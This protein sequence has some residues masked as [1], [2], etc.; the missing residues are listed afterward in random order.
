[1]RIKL[2]KKN[3]F[4]L[5]LFTYVIL[6]QLIYIFFCL[7]SGDTYKLFIIFCFIYEKM[8]NL[9]FFLAYFMQKG[10]VSIIYTIFR[11]TEF[12]FKEIN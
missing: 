12:F 7:Q 9:K 10:S 6:I 11:T 8:M 5:F 1:M 3:K 2:I 4:F